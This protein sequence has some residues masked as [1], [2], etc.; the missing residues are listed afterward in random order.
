MTSDNKDAQN[1]INFTC[2]N[3]IMCDNESELKDYQIAITNDGLLYRGYVVRSMNLNVQ[4]FIGSSALD[5]QKAK[6]E[7][8][9]IE[10]AAGYQ[11]TASQIASLRETNERFNSLNLDSFI[12]KI[13]DLIEYYT[14]NE[15]ISKL[16]VEASR[17]KKL[18]T[19]ETQDEYNKVRQ[20]ITD[21]DAKKNAINQAIGKQLEVINNLN[22]KLTDTNNYLV[23]I[24]H[25][26]ETLA[27]DNLA[28]DSDCQ[29]EYEEMTREMSID[30]AYN[31]CQKRLDSV[32]STYENMTSGI[33]NKQKDYVTEFNSNL[34]VG[35]SE[36][37]TYMAELDKLEKTE[38]VKYEAKVRQARETA[39]IIFKEDF[40]SKLRDNI[41]TAEN[42]IS[43]INET[44][45]SIPFGNDTYEFIFPKS[46]EYGGFYDMFKS[47]DVADGKSMFTT[48][49]EKT[50][51]EQLDQLFT[52]IASDS[53]DDNKSFEKFTDYRTYMDYDIK[54]SNQYGESMLYS[55][56][57][58]EKSGGETQVPFYVAMIASFVRIYTQNANNSSIGIV[59]LDEVFDKMDSTR[60]Q[61][62]M[63]FMTSMPL[64]FIL[65]CPPQRM[66]IIANYVDTTIIVFRKE[67][68]T[69]V[70]PITTK[71][72]LD[73]IKDSISEEVE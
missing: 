12:A 52:A 11:E 10:A 59:M 36:C 18:S 49:F 9:S 14:I 57:F 6:L 73:K 43:K 48:D 4:K 72:E 42:E 44:L 7:S 45:S 8:D 40:I 23:E 41:A 63:N 5:E 15:K 17:A 67:Y 30:Q 66:N 51:T 22:K 35:I 25:T 33:I 21:A 38:L 68:K 61:A 39:E 29:K 55:K 60:M 70:M 34:S 19:T 50:Y 1:Y 31:S 32:K 65:A 46:K 2:G 20:E 13:E 71:E 64:Q 24:N 26:L 69:Q 62:M 16:N 58:R 3:V 47:E 37:P 53:L 28:L 54:I 27:S 56:V